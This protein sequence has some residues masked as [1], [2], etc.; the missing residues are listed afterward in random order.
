M[1]LRTVMKV[2]EHETVLESELNYEP[3]AE[4]KSPIDP[5]EK[6]VMNIESLR[7]MEEKVFIH[8]QEL[9]EKYPDYIDFRYV[10]EEKDHATG[11]KSGW[12]NLVGIKSYVEEEPENISK[13]SPIVGGLK[14]SKSK[15]KIIGSG[16]IGIGAKSAFGYS[17]SELWEK[18]D[19][20]TIKMSDM[21]DGHLDNAIKMCDR[22]IVGASTKE[23]SAH[24]QERKQKLEREKIVVNQWYKKTMMILWMC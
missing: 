11:G 23:E 14:K 2:A 5:I 3:F 1:I 24:W 20:T 12:F 9:E 16:G 8:F 21:N 18:R 10:Y 7:E 22:K 17:S 19:G 15:P 4:D 13:P 6:L